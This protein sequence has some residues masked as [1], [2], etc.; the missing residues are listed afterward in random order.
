LLE[1]D[2]FE[3]GSWWRAS[4]ETGLLSRKREWI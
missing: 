1:G 4:R 2:G 3:L